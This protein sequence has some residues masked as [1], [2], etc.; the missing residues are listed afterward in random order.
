[1]PIKTRAAL[2]AIAGAVAYAIAAA[3]LPDTT[4]QGGQFQPAALLTAQAET[5]EQDGMMGEGEGGM[6]DMMN[7]M[8]QMSRMM[9]SCNKMME[10]E[11][12]DEQR[13]GSGEETEM[14]RQ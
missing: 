11:L 8:Q 4:A 9:E 10:T 5:T 2:L 3:L 12:N 7:M 1:M 13:P 6:M 14:P